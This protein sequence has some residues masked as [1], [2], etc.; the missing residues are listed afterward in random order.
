MLCLASDVGLVP[1]RLHLF[2]HNTSSEPY[3]MIGDPQRIYHGKAFGL[4]IYCSRSDG[5]YVFLIRIRP[6][7]S[8]KV[9]ACRAMV[10]N[11]VGTTCG[12][13]SDLQ[14][15]SKTTRKPDELLA[16]IIANTGYMFMHQLTM[17]VGSFSYHESTRSTASR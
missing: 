12:M 2:L 8:P 17:R 16:A 9:L 7:G 6:S 5:R 15:L 11:N 1:K 10:L 4:P 13:V 14:N 3:V